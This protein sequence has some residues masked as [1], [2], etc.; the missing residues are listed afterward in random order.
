MNIVD[1]FKEITTDEGKHEK[2]LKTTVEGQKCNPLLKGWV[3]LNKLYDLQNISQ[4]PRNSR[5]HKPTTTNKQNNVGSNNNLKIVNL[6]TNY[7]PPHWS[8]FDYPIKQYRNVSMWVDDDL[9]T[10]DMRIT[11]DEI[12]GRGGA[13]TL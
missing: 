8:T 3:P 4:G 2:L 12:P 13:K 9:S 7:T 5:T 6:S 11:Q 1:T 10:Y